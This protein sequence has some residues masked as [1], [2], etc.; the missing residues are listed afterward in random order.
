MSDEITDQIASNALQP[1]SMSVDGQTVT[2]HSLQDQIAA[3]KFLQAQTAA[4][5]SNCGLR[6]SKIV[7][8]GATGR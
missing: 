8:P 3:A 7:P 2:E 5:G 4:Q 6:F 1:Q